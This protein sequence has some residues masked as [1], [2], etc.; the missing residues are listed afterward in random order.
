MNYSLS[1]FYTCKPWLLFRLSVM[2]DRLTDKGELICEYCGKPIVMQYD[3]IAH[4]KEELTERNVNDAMVS[5]NPDNIMLVHHKCHNKI[6]DKLGSMSYRQ[7]V[8]LVYGAPLSGKST[9]VDSV[10]LPGDLIV[11]MD[12]IWECVSGCPRYVKPYRLKAV[13]FGVRDKLLEDVRMRKGKWK[14]AYVIGGYPLISERERLVNSL[15]AEEVLIDCTREECMKRLEAC[16][17][18]RG[19][20]WE[21]FISEWFRLYSPQ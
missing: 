17:D 7:K 19:K 5:L 6:H 12:S 13:V 16:T 9:W 3:C 8:Y 20:E 21:R 1:N 15:G 11:D 18:G 10:K 4:H 2:N 14:N